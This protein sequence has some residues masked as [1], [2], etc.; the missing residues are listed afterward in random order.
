MNRFLSMLKNG[1]SDEIPVW[2]MRQAGR[3]LKE[4][5]EKKGKRT[6]NEVCM[7]PGL[8][9]EITYDPVRI[10][11]VDAAIIFSDI[12]IPLEALGYKI[13]FM[14]GGPRIINGYIKNHDMN[15]IIYFDEAN[16]NYKIYDAIK[17]FKD[18]YKFPLIGFSGGLI[19]VLSYII[20]E[21]PDNNLGMTKKVLLSDENI[22]N[23]IN[24]VKDMIIKY[25]KLQIKAGVDAIQIFDS[26]LGYISPYTYEKYVK[27]HI[28]DIISEINVPVI[29]FS[30]G[31]SSII[32]KISGLNVD[33]ISV[34]WRLD[35][36]LARSMVNDK[37]LQG[38]LD[39][40]VAAYN[41]KAALSES[42][43]IIKSAGVENYIFNLGHGVIP[44]TPVEN[45][46]QIV[47]FVHNFKH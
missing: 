17:I 20:A 26:W 46:K 40:Y 2:F 47:N 21:G 14:P 33:Y 4:Y 41:L 38:N 30:T 7:D 3:Y 28:E 15:G 24:I 8:V 44:D 31:T 34:D 42:S 9:A 27:E 19:T 29:Y 32:E 37:G 25:I 13:E 12:T 22:N 45:L 16:F 18:K 35:M 43:D 10:L 23:Y 39:P 36:S 6:I 5:N 1:S 11:G